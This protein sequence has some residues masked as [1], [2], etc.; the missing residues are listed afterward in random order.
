MINAFEGSAREKKKK[1]RSAAVACAKELS[2][3]VF[4]AENNM[5]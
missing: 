2:L 3:I 4:V 5:L 1:V